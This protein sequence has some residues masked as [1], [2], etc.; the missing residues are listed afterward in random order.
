MEVRERAA[1]T[2]EATHEQFRPPPPPPLP[3]PS[4]WQRGLAW[5]GLVLAPVLGL[6]IG[7]FSIYV[8]ALV[9]WVLFGWFVAG[10]GYLVRGMPRSPRDPYDDGSR[11]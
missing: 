3:R 2:Y 10:F 9:G 7:L 8:P 6:V 11:V 5:A 1:A 4:T